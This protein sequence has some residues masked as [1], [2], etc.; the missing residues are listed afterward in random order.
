MHD[1]REP[2]GEAVLLADTLLV[3]VTDTE[4]VEDTVEL[5]EGVLVLVPLEVALIEAD[6]L[7]LALLLVLTV[8]DTV[9]LVEA[10]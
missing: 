7:L 4:A 3:L 6:L 5:M 2:D 1:L 9:G 8:D 10:V